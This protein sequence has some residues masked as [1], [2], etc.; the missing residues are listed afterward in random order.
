[1]DG[2]ILVH[3]APSTIPTIGGGSPNEPFLF[4]VDLH[5]QA[6]CEGTKNKDPNFYT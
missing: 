6:D 4:T 1:V 3:V 2:M 5:Y